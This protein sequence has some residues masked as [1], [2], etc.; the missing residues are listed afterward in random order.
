V[1]KPSNQTIEPQTV[2]Q[3]VRQSGNQAVRQSGNLAI[4]QHITLRVSLGQATN[5]ERD[6]IFL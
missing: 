4:K 5:P 1:V 6:I 3:A 2:R